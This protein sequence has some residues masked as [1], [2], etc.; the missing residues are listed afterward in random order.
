MKS[1]FGMI[2]ICFSLSTF[3]QEKNDAKPKTDIKKLDLSKRASDHLMIQLGYAGWG[4]KGAITTKGFSKTYNMYFMFDFPFKSDPHYSVALGPGIG[5]DNIHLKQTTVDLS[6][7]GGATITRDTITN[8]KKYKL[9]SGYLELPL[10]FRYAS[11]PENMNKGWK[12]A[13]GL[14]IGTIA[15]GKIKAKVNLDANKKG[16]YILKYEDHKYFS[17][18]RIAATARAGLGNVSVF[19]SYTLSDF[20]KAGYGPTVRPFSFGLAISGL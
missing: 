6:H 12:F 20:F 16:G 3:A 14:K 15:D 4:N 5:S 19:G 2:L 10:E 8:Y 9:A 11:K 7:T 18:T 13:L 1:I 17:G